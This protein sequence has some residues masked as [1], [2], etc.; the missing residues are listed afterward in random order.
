M[1]NS[2]RQR[3]S[4][5]I[6]ASIAFA[7][8]V[9]ASPAM[10]GSTT[11]TIAVSLN[12]SAACAVNGGTLTTGAL[13]QVGAIAFADQPGVFGDVSATMVATGGGGGLSIL[14]SPGLTPSLTVGAGAHDSGSLH[15]LAFGSNEVAYHLYSDSARTNE[16]TIGQ[17]ISLGT[18]TTTA[19][20]LP[21]F[22][23][24]NSGGLALPAGAYVDTVQVTL[25][26]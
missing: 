2:T 25:S 5:T 8:F 15:H 6:C 18:A 17:Q 24:T 7:G 3:F 16:L 21:I 13:G 22:A 10:A 19:F 12:V 1:R 9:S 20:S 26:W 4:K 23:K 11:G 14:C